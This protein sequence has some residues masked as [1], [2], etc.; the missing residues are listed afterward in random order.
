MSKKISKFTATE[1]IVII[2][3]IVLL[4]GIIGVIVY[5]TSDSPSKSKKRSSR[6]KKD[7]SSY[8]SPRE[9]ARRSNCMGNLKQIG[10]ALKSYSVSEN[11]FP[12]WHDS[13]ES[14]TKALSLLINSGELTDYYVFVCP[15]S[16]T[17][18]G[19]A[20]VDLRNTNDVANSLVG[21]ISYAYIPGIDSAAGA[22]SGIMAD[23]YYDSS[24]INHNRYGNIMMGDG[25]VK[26]STGTDSKNWIKD[27]NWISTAPGVDATWLESDP[28]KQYGPKIRN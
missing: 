6:D 8:V 27:A 4:L 15:S 9:R 13:S 1:L 20:P 22:S 25:S 26:G 21:H 17:E 16:K 3:A 12:T 11:L 5:V 28:K 23:G 19:T 24:K 7:D 10:S 18:R 14:G 2:V